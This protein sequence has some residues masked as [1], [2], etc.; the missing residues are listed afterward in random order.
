M[1]ACFGG[2]MPTH[3]IPKRKELEEVSTLTTAV[4]GSYN[5]TVVETPCVCHVYVCNVL[6]VHVYVCMHVCVCVCACVGGGGEVIRLLAQSYL[7][8]YM[9]IV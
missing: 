1:T 9:Y 8:N 7:P 3:D 5:C 2:Q 4:Y 6:C